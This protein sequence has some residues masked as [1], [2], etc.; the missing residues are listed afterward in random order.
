MKITTFLTVSARLRGFQSLRGPLVVSLALLAPTLHGQGE[1]GFL[2]GEGNLDLAITYTHDTYDK[3]WVGTDKVAMP[4]VG[5]VDRTGYGLYAAYGLTDD[6]DLVLSS[7]YVEAESDGIAGAPDEH[8]LQDVVLAAKWRV[9]R[10]RQSWGEAWLALAPGLKLPGSDYENNAITAIGDGQ[11]DWRGRLIGHLQ[12]NDG[13]FASLETGYDRRN[14]AP[15]DEL[16]FH[17]TVGGTIAERFT[18]A[19]FFS[20]VESLGGTDIGPPGTNDFPTNEEDFTRVGVSCYARVSARFGLTASW[21]TT[22]DG[23]NTGDVEGFSMGVVL[24]F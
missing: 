24:R 3:F 19:P 9:A 2:R 23:R 10:A 4:G 11:I 12:T 13:W 21:R 6:L 7:A 15:R 18:V 1:T 8:D 5:E 22:L 16:P 14:G 20:H 17:L